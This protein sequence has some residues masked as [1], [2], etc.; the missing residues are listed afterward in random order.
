[1]KT[2]TSSK[3]DRNALK[4]AISAVTLQLGLARKQ[5]SSEETLAKRAA[6]KA[7]RDAALDA[8]RAVAKRDP[9]VVQGP[10]VARARAR[11]PRA[12]GVVALAAGEE[13]VAGAYGVVGAVDDVVPVDL[14]IPGCPPTPADIIAALRTVTGR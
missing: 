6:R 5:G 12:D 8:V 11:L 13:G 1:M 7:R 3:I 2:N 10:V 9:E 4:A 14:E